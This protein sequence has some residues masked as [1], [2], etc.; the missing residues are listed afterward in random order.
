M[1]LSRSTSC[2]SFFA[3]QSL[4]M[5][6]ICGSTLGSVA[7]A[8]TFKTV[9]LD[10][11]D[12]GRQIGLSANA[13]TNISQFSLNIG[14][15]LYSHSNDKLSKFEV[16]LEVD[17]DIFSHSKLSGSVSYLFDYNEYFN[18]GLW[19][20]S[21]RVSFNLEYD[22]GQPTWMAVSISAENDRSS[23]P[24]QD[25]TLI[26][27]G[28]TYGIE[29]GSWDVSGGLSVGQADFESSVSEVHKQLDWVISREVSSQGSL[30]LSLSAA[31]TVDHFTING[32]RIRDSVEV[33]RLSISLPY[34]VSDTLKVTP[35]ATYEDLESE[36]TSQRTTTYAL[37]IGYSF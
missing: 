4:R 6:L 3:N 33:Y 20:S 2:F 12:D 30:K 13:D 14:G 15:S 10:V 9:T 24:G 36:T 23:V 28:L 18:S 11:S 1:K 5:S 27:F 8:E 26:D 19:F 29:I 21:D 35:S 32:L 25:H 7:Y 34:S 16:D 37:Q 31:D 17:R 22:G